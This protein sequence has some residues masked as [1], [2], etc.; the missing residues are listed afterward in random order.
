MVS[1]SGSSSVAGILGAALLIG[2]GVGGTLGVQRVTGGESK[3]CTIARDWADGYVR[4]LKAQPPLSDQDAWLKNISMMNGLYD[5]AFK[6]C[7]P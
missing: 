6:A 2:V 7:H 5:V 1:F 3:S 4:N